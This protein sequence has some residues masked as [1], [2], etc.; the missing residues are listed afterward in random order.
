MSQ[1]GTTQ[2]K[3]YKD[4]R[5]KQSFRDE[6]DI[7]IIMKRAQKTGT[8]SHLNKHEGIYG[9]FAG[10]DFFA[11][12]LMLTRGR[13]IFDELPPE[14]RSEFEN[15]PA[16]FFKYVNDPENKDRL[17]VLLPGLAEPGRQN[18]TIKPPTADEAAAAAASEAVPSSTT[19]P[20]AEPPG[21]PEVPPEAESGAP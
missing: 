1:L 6:T 16:D 19:T 5:T 18:L 12:T 17:D 4:G 3:K 10:Y 13:E 21:K 2:P 7:N 15:S 11:N 9:D 14:L 20:P 8:I